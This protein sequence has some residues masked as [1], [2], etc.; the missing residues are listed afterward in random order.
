MRE[1]SRAAMSQPPITTG[2]LI[3]GMPDDLPQIQC[4]AFAKML[5][6]RVLMNAEVEALSTRPDKDIA[7][8]AS[9]EH[10]R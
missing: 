6:R 4:A 5:R 2:F 8:E 10:A 9:S 3:R 1:A 7:I